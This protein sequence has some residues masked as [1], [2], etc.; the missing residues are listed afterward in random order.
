MSPAGG[1]G[2]GNTPA[3]AGKTKGKDPKKWGFEKH[4]RL[5]GEDFTVAGFDK[6][7]LETPPLARGRPALP[8]VRL[9]TRET[10]PLARGRRYIG[11]TMETSI[12]NTPPCAG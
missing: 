11:E 10:P 4:P 9:I 2:L 3:C 12:R 5:R 8:P 1:S 7:P 6:E